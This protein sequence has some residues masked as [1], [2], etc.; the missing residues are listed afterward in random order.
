MEAVEFYR[1]KWGSIRVIKES[2]GK[3]PISDFLDE[4]A[5]S[6]RIKLLALM[7]RAADMGPRNINDGQKFKKL[8]GSLLEFKAFQARVPC[9]Y[10][11]RSLVLTHGFS[12]KQNRTPPDELRRAKRIM[13]QFQKSQAVPPPP[14]NQKRPRKR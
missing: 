10:D 11:D 3:I 1:G 9:F 5:D 12:K 13:A 7:K 4:L 6:E 14:H 8:E 2:D